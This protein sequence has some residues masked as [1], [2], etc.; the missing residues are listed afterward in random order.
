MK[1]RLSLC[2]GGSLGARLRGMGRDNLGLGRGPHLPSSQQRLLAH[3]SL[4]LVVLY[5]PYLLDGLR[6]QRQ[7]NK[8]T[9]PEK[10]PCPPDGQGAAE[11]GVF[12][13][14]SDRSCTQ[15]SQEEG[16]AEEE[17]AA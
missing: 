2:L 16:W 3:N 6:V 14:V 15:C 4:P 1:T 7:A 9:D 8:K 13:A 10:L 12:F 17:K 11:T 5:M